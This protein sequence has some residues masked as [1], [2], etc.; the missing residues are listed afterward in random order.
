MSIR[1]LILWPRVMRR[2]VIPVSLSKQ[3]QSS[4][5]AEE[6]RI[7]TPITFHCGLSNSFST[8]VTLLRIS[9]STG[10]TIIRG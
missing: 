7:Q 10:E 8:N 2:E 4:P 9:N 1:L 5:Q 3:G 6:A